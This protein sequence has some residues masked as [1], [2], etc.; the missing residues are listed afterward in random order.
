MANLSATIPVLVLALVLN[1]CGVQ[2]TSA[3]P[4]VGDWS[5]NAPPA[6]IHVTFEQDGDFSFDTTVPDGTDRTNGTYVLDGNTLKLQMTDASCPSKYI[7]TEATH[8]V[9]VTNDELTMD[10][11]VFDKASPE[12]G[13][14]KALGCVADDGTFSK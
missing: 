2:S 1:G 13:V 7:A 5:I 11:I 4:I 14:P 6:T 10:G 12:V 3:D 9:T 8:A